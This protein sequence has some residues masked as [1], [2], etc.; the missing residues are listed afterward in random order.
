VT[1][2]RR[3]T[4]LA[5]ALTV[6]TAAAVA[7]VTGIAPAAGATTKQFCAAYKPFNLRYAAQFEAG[8]P[9][10]AKVA[11]ADDELDALVTRVEKA[12]PKAVADDVQTVAALFHRGLAKVVATVVAGNKDYGNALYRVDEWALDHC[13]YRVLDVTAFDF[14]FRGIPKT[15]KPGFVAFGVG[16]DSEQDH[17]FMVVRMK[18][19]LTA[20]DL[21]SLTVNELLQRVEVIAA[22]VTAPPGL[23]V[24]NYAQ[25]DRPGL[26]AALDPNFLDRKMIAEFRVAKAR[27]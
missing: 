2:R 16:N 12:A 7:A 24:A 22:P 10:A 1:L 27:T 18:G 8:V 9:T 26:Y 13:D 15:V 11:A 14:G 17:L 3:A 25:I 6:V 23:R 21:A 20:E 5:C 19:D 4:R